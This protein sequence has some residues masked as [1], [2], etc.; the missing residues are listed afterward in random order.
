MLATGPSM[1]EAVASAV[2]GRGAV[3]AVSDAFQLAPWADALVSTD[4]QWW[5]VHAAA[6][7]FSGRK[8]AAVDI[9][10]VERV[11]GV[12]R[13]INSGLLALQVAVGEFG[14][15]TVVLLGIDLHGS[16][17]FGDHPAPLFNSTDAQFRSMNQCFR[18]YQPAGV[19]IIN[20]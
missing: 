9:D 16:H 19:R 15:T 11:P 4:R 12:P 2:R 10:G 8:F 6:P 20:C 5:D 18:Q 13:D 14:A 17:F 7:G 3:I 1:N